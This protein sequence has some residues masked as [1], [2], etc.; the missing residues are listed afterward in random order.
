MHPFIHHCISPTCDKT[1]KDEF[2][3]Q[4]RRRRPEV[5]LG[6]SRAHWKATDLRGLTAVPSA[7]RA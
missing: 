7:R 6:S 2:L 3:L 1:G 5:Y 4:I